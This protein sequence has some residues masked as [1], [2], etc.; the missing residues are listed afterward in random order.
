[1]NKGLK[2]TYGLVTLPLIV[3]LGLIAIRY[4]EVITMPMEVERA[5]PQ[6][7]LHTQTNQV[8]SQFL[9]WGSIVFIL[10]LITFSLIVLLWPSRYSKINLYE[11]GSGKLLLR[12]TALEGFV[13]SVVDAQDVMT[14]PVVKTSIYGKQLK[15]KVTGCLNSRAAAPQQL[16][17]LEQEIREGLEA[18]FGLP[19][20][21][22]FTVIAKEI[23]DSSQRL[24]S[25]VE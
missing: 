24:V 2:W 23:V 19:R 21:L 3:L 17:N 10:I 16:S 4:S 14:E 18:F 7:H 8:V 11:D 25:R 15:V 20:P 5:L 9:F 13:R 22:Q 6:W 1:M 12:K